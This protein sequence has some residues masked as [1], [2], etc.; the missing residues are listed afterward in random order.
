MDISLITDEDTHVEITLIGYDPDGDPLE[1]FIISEPTN[2]SLSGIPPDVTYNPDANY[3]GSDS[4]SFQVNDG[5]GGT[6]TAT[7]SLTV[8]SVNDPPVAYDDAAVTK[9][10]TPV[11]IDVLANDRDIDGDALTIASV[12]SPAHGTATILG[13]EIRYT[14]DSGYA[15]SDSFTYTV[16]DGHGG[17]DTATVSVTIN[18]VNHPPVAYD[19]S[20]TADCFG[21]ADTHIILQAEDPDGDPLNYIIVS[22]PQEGLL[23]P[24]SSPA[25]FYYHAKLS[26]CCDCYDHFTFKVND[27]ELDSNTATVTI[28][29]D[30]PEQ[31]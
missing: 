26:A 9:E 3:N 16:S 10:D 7:V 18:P 23:I 4:F 27:G 1:Y 13:D 5:Y 14:P 21:S 20:Y 6:A 30:P 24:G 11:T 8:N 25:E 19:D 2:G 28:W 31:P 17:T 15:G 29:L 22:G 12:S